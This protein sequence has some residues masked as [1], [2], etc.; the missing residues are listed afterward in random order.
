MA[1]PFQGWPVD[2]MTQAV[3]GRPNLAMLR[4]QL[5]LG[6]GGSSRRVTV[7]GQ[8]QGEERS[9]SSQHLSSSSQR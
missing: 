8:S 9:S 2:E 7:R 3:L 5:T 1:P 6:T 4:V